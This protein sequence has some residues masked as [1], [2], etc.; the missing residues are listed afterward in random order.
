MVNINGDGSAWGLNSMQFIKE[1]MLRS[2]AFYSIHIDVDDLQTYILE[3]IMLIHYMAQTMGQHDFFPIH[4][5]EE[6]TTLY[7]LCFAMYFYYFVGIV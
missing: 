3:V 2:P 5:I 1:K 6:Y 7:M 4:S